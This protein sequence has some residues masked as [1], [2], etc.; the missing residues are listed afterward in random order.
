M[1]ASG[2]ARRNPERGDRVR[3]SRSFI[4]GQLLRGL[5]SLR[6]GTTMAR[7]SKEK[8]DGTVVHYDSLAEMEAADE[9]SIS[10][11]AVL[12]FFAGGIVAFIGL[13]LLGVS[14]LPAWAKF[15]VVLAAAIGSSYVG[16]RFRKAIVTGIV[17]LFLL[18]LLLL[19]AFILWWAV[20]SI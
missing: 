13:A 9:Q 6:R 7:Y 15:I 17:F 1:W 12:F 20:S 19:G 8:F 3:E 4:P 2:A 5:V 14:W 18:L 11:I 16:W 10:W